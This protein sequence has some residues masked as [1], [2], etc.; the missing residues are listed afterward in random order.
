MQS[1]IL[2]YQIDNPTISLLDI[3]KRF[4]KGTPDAKVMKEIKISLSGAKFVATIMLKEPEGGYFK[5]EALT[6]RCLA[7]NIGLL[8]QYCQ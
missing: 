6:G 8:M 7:T 3:A 2:I 5:E 1:K 4:S